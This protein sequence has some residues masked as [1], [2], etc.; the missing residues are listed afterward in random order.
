MSAVRVDITDRLVQVRQGVT[1]LK[2]W[3]FK[4]DDQKFDSQ[5][6]R[7]TKRAAILAALSAVE[8]H[9]LR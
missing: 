3:A 4:V 8:C 1:E 2:V 9:V 5:N 6:S 7:Q